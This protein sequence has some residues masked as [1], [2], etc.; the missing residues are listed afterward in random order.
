MNWFRFLWG[1]VM[2]RDPE[3]STSFWEMF[4]WK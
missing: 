3:S 4:G 2:E 1:E